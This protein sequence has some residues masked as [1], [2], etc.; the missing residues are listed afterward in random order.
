MLIQ[1]C[2]CERRILTTRQIEDN[3]PCFL[4]QAE[5]AVNDRVEENKQKEEQ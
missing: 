4:C 1:W 2:K 5:K 3:Q